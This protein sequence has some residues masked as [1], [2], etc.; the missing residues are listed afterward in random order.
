MISL[1]RTWDPLVVEMSPYPW[2]RRGNEYYLTP[3]AVLHRLIGVRY[4]RKTSALSR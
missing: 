1:L 2:V 3:L 4:P